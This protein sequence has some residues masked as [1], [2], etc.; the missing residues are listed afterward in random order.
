MLR[1]SLDPEP[2]LDSDFWLNPDSMNMDPKH[3]FQFTSRFCKIG[4]SVYAGDVSYLLR[5]P[6]E[7]LFSSS[8]PLGLTVKILVWG[9][10]CC[11][12]TLGLS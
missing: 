9:G 5:L 7:P 12:W 2:D 4:E 6:D 10:R 3:C 11:C 1:N 8:E